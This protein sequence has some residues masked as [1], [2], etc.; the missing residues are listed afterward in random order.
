MD[1]IKVKLSED[2]GVEIMKLAD[3]L[4]KN[5]V[6]SAIITQIIKSGTSIGANI[7]EAVCAES[8]QDFIHK[9]KISEKEAIE[10]QFWLRILYRSN[11][12][13]ENYF[14]DLMEKCSTLKKILSSIIMS[15]KQNLKSQ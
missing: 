4:G 13:D 15:T 9:L 5:K 10:T 12:L 11:K 1:D 14:V 2:F 7:N 3:Y 8:K 6:N